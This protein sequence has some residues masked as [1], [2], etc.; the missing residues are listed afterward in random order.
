MFA[1]KLCIP[2]PNADSSPLPLSWLL[3]SKAD[4]VHSLPS[5][6]P[7]WIGLNA[8]YNLLKGPEGTHWLLL[9]SIN[10][11]RNQLSTPAGGQVLGEHS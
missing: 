2:S 3:G 5:P 11:N 10:S 7:G 8:I 4:L 6:S 1:L 9:R